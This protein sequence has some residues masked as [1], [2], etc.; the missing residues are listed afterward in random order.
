[1]SQGYFLV[2]IDSEEVQVIVEQFLTEFE[3]SSDDVWI[4]A[5][6]SAEGQWTWVNGDVYGDSNFFLLYDV[7]SANFTP[8]PN[9]GAL[10]RVCSC[11]I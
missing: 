2:R 7:V 9:W 10:E 3:L 1:M 5:N 8:Q 4:G 11:I 6:R